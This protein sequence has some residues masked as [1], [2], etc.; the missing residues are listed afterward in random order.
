MCA[1]RNDEA[2]QLR[3]RVEVLERQLDVVR[4]GAEAFASQIQ[5]EQLVLETLRVSVEAVGAE[6]G[7]IILYEPDHEMLVFRYVLPEHAS[8][9][10]GFEMAPTDGIAGS[11]FTT[12]QMRV[13]EDVSKADE[14][15]RD[16]AEKVGYATENMVTLPLK[17]PGGE[18]IGVMQ[19]LNKPES[20]FTDD[21]CG[22]LEILAAQAALMLENARL[23]EEARLAEV[24]NRLGDIS[25]DIKNM[26]TPVES[27]AQT[28]EMAF[29]DAFASVDAALSDKPG[30]DPQ[31]AEDVNNGL[32]MLR[33]FY[34]DAVEMLLDGA[35]RAQDRVR[36]IADCV[37]GMVSE[38]SF[39]W[40][41]AR[42]VA[43][44]VFTLQAMVAERA[45]VTLR[46]EAPD[47]VPPAPLD[48]R[49]LFNAIYNLV[50]NAIPETPP[51][52]TIAVR[53]CATVDGETD[54]GNCLI[55]EVADDGKGMTEEVR[56]TLFTDDARST[57]PG[58]TGLGTRIV[59]SA[60]EAHAGEVSVE[61]RPGEGSTFTMRL[62]LERE[63]M[64]PPAP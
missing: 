10:E 9:L 5:F 61:S 53:V 42:D 64:A 48:E 23:N 7:S 3:S 37:K 50:G 31:V 54:E 24:V 35:A 46:M 33:E 62:P 56:S 52:G 32:A 20:P 40:V 28:L 16:V 15:R 38:P 11:V 58:G 44:R 22:L 63:G 13:S 21:D 55:I 45:G 6:A 36:E 8:A 41:D 19:V 1:Q 12:G 60:V 51:G 4:A 17:R 59:K 30:L 29:E 57:K 49:R 27:C 47:D 34:P 14:H 25:H 26:L 39:D 18:S 43:A 2:S